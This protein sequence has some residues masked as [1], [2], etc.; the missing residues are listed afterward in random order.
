M[1]LKFIDMLL[2]FGI[3]LEVWWLVFLGYMWLC[4]NKNVKGEEF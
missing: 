3:A 4:D 2:A 1:I